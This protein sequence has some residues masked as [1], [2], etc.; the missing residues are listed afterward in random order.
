[1]VRGRLEAQLGDERGQ[2]EAGGFLWV[3]RGTAHRFAN[4]GPDP[5]PPR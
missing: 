1:M 5:A 2:V 4:A 3:P